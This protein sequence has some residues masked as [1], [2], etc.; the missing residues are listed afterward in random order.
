LGVLRFE[1][2][3]SKRVRGAKQN[4]THRALRRGG[5]ESG[6]RGGWRMRFLCVCALTSAR[7]DQLINTTDTLMI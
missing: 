1:R 4:K 2:N 3:N 5:S 6:G 7:A